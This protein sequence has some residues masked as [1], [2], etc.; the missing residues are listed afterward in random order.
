MQNILFL[1]DSLTAGYGL[2]NT[3]IESFPARIE[4]KINAAKLEYN[5]I[6]AGLSGDTSGGGLNRIAYWLSRPV[7]I[8][9]LELG[10]NDIIRGI[11]PQTIFRNLQAI[12][13]KVKARYPN[14]KIALM[15]MRIPAFIPS[16]FAVQ[17]NAI[18]LKLANDNQA[19]FVP[20]FLDGVAGKSQFNLPD[21]LHPNAEGYKVIADN[22]WPVIKKLVMDHPKG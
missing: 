7:S 2:H 8:F 20:F 18:Y 11:S 13:D 3:A 1:G 10:I 15:G 19:A 17:F 12:I 5:V 9:V 16:T 4:Q 22:V 6:N 14:V 21:R